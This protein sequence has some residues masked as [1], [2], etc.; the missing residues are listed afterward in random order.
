MSFSYTNA[1]KMRRQQRKKTKLEAAEVAVRRSLTA[2]GVVLPLLARFGNESSW[3]EQVEEAEAGT[4]AHVNYI[5]SG[6][7]NPA[8][9]MQVAEA[10][11]KEILGPLFMDRA[12]DKNTRSTA[13]VS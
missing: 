2:V 6:E 5:W 1:K 11:V 4:K 8:T 12:Q 13:S 3:L 7:N 10:K 9:E